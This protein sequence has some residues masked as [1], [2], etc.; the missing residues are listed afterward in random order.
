MKYEDTVPGD[1]PWKEYSSIRRRGGTRC[2][3]PPDVSVTPGGPPRHDSLPLIMR[4]K[5]SR[6][7][8]SCRFQGKRCAPR[9]SIPFSGRPPAPRRLVERGRLPRAASS[10]VTVSR[11]RRRRHG[12][13]LQKG[14]APFCP[15]PRSQR[16][17]HK[18]ISASSG[19]QERSLP[20]LS[21]QLRIARSLIYLSA[22]F[23]CAYVFIKLFLRTFSA[24]LRPRNRFNCT[25]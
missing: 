6:L 5:I 2:P 11:P 1:T 10:S 4:A 25:T 24:C 7:I 14:S 8:Q 12:N 20:K 3:R 15:R 9:G 17:R 21:T 23:T 22:L 16:K 13:A 18:F 19:A